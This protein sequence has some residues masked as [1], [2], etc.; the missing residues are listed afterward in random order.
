MKSRNQLT[1][2]NILTGNDF[3]LLTCLVQPFLQLK[4]FLSDFVRFSRN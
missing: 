3:D 1:G 2:L 4:H